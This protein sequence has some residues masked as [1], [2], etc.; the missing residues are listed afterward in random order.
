MSVAS[1]PEPVALFQSSLLLCVKLPYTSAVAA[2]MQVAES[3]RMYQL[4]RYLTH[5]QAEASRP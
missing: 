2:H 4:V 1:L 5:V 3:Y